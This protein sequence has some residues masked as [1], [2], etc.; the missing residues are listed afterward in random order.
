VAAAN[1]TS[2]LFCGLQYDYGN[3]ALGPSFEYRN[4]YR[5]LCSLPAVTAEFWPIDVAIRQHGYS[6][7]NRILVERCN[8][9]SP[10]VLFCILNSDEVAR[11][12]L[13]TI[14]PSVLKF[15]L[16]CDD[17]W[18]FECFSRRVARE[19]D[20]YGTTCRRAVERYLR[21]GLKEVIYLPWAASSFRVPSSVADGVLFIGQKYGHR[22]PYINSLCAAGIEVRAFGTGW[23]RR[24]AAED[25]TAFYN[26]A[27]INLNFSGCR[28]RLRAIFAERTWRYGAVP[29]LHPFTAARSAWQAAHSRQ[30]KA[31]IF[32]VTA[33]GGFLLT[34][35]SEDLPELFRIGEELETFESA[36][37]LIDRCRYYIAHPERRARIAA[38]GYARCV[39][40]HSY[41]HHLKNL[42]TTSFR[43]SG[44]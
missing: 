21:A 14:R 43:Y 27:A 11:E 42:F 33:A 13:R 19:F 17:D 1:S 32:E 16:F 4:L 5:S 22:A 26:A 38:A 10:D 29:N 18:R 7:A 12:T 36:D 8:D 25:L 31:R 23:G 24:V 40:D 3:P 20:A 6:A 2:V 9:L 35:P 15:N 30:T 37:E 39:R 34:E 41:L 28:S 44:M